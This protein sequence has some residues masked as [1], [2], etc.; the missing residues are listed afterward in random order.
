MNFWINVENPS[1]ASVYQASWF[2]YSIR[3]IETFEALRA[4]HLSLSVLLYIYFSHGIPLRSV[5][6]FTR[7]LRVTYFTLRECR[8]A[9]CVLNRP[10]YEPFVLRSI[11]SAFSVYFTSIARIANI[12][13]KFRTW[14]QRRSLYLVT[15]FFILT[16]RAPL[17]PE[18]NDITLE[19]CEAKASSLTEFELYF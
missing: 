4:I 1:V 5:F 10:A 11:I 17:A 9:K 8:Y 14:L 12:P 13:A 19:W 2:W 18:R 16:Y 6:Y 3:F 15:I 7:T